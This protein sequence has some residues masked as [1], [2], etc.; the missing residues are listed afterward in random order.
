MA[1]DQPR[2]QLHTTVSKMWLPIN[3]LQLPDILFPQIT[4]DDHVN[5][6][7]WL[8]FLRSIQ[9]RRRSR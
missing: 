9:D 8:E 4:G 5:D 1:E 7:G 6:G 3:F 2:V